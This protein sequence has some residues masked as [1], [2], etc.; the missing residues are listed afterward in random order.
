MIDGHICAQGTLS[1]QWD[2]DAVRHG[3]EWGQSQGLRLTQAPYSLC[4]MAQDCT[5]SLI[6]IS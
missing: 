6:C 2:V 5:Y 1:A 4:G 3:T